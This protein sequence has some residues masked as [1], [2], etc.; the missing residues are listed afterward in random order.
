MLKALLQKRKEYK[1]KE[2]RDKRFKKIMFQNGLIIESLKR[3]SAL[4]ALK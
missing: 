4:K 3:K 1:S 2:A